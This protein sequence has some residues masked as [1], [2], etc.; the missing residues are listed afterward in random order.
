MV[1]SLKNNS[2]N[3]ERYLP[4]ILDSNPKLSTIVPLCVVDV[5]DDY[6]ASFMIKDL[7]ERFDVGV[8]TPIKKDLE[9][10]LIYRTIIKTKGRD[11]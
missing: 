3:V 4:Q 7:D 5:S 10:I 8:H 6:Y 11:C 2:Y 1:A 9:N